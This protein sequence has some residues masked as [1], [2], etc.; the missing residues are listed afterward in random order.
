MKDIDFQQFL[1]YIED[2]L[3]QEE[4]RFMDTFLQHGTISCLQHS[5]VV[6]YYSYAFVKKFHI[7]CDER[8]LVRG[9]LLH[10]YFLYD[11]HDDEAWHKWHGFRHP[12]FALQNAKRDFILTKRE[13]DI[14]KK[15]MWPLTLVP[16]LH[17]ESWIVTSV[18]KTSSLLEVLGTKKYFHK[19]GQ[20]WF[21][22]YEHIKKH[23]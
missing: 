9:A 2:I 8:S 18:D 3:Q 21:A 16:P 20:R 11:W 10:D 17:R 1:R 14:I 13:Q 23:F 12:N 6:S 4:V 15:H 19:I 22:P 5:L 7:P